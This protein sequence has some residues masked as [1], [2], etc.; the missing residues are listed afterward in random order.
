MAMGTVILSYNVY[1]TPLFLLLVVLAM[2]QLPKGTSLATEFHLS[3]LEGVVM[4]L[5]VVPVNTISV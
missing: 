3:K 1:C 4:P 2:S 5:P